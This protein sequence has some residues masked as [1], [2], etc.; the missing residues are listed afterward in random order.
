MKRYEVVRFEN[1][2]YG[3]KDTTNNDTV[4]AGMPRNAAN[5]WCDRLNLRHVWGI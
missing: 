2:W 5:Q 4:A 1:G 3:V